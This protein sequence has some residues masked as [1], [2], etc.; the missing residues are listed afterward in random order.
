M[1]GDWIFSFVSRLN[2]PIK[3]AKWI[4]SCFSEA[5][6]WY[7]D[8]SKIIP[9]LKAEVT[10]K[11]N[12]ARDLS[13][14]ILRE[15]SSR[16][17]GWFSFCDSNTH[18]PHFASPLSQFHR[19]FF[20]KL[21]FQSVFS[22]LLALFEHLS[23]I[24]LPRLYYVLS[25]Q[26]VVYFCFNFFSFDPVSQMFAYLICLPKKPFFSLLLLL[27]TVS[28]F[29]MLLISALIFIIS[30]PSNSFGFIFCCPNF[31]LRTV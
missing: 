19:V 30:F 27:L 13:A 8:N 1:K 4:F 3:W 2:S 25:N 7:Y 6:L 31:F 22:G 29:V 14:C 15:R 16:R 17:H 23:F 18:Q 5:I 28:L 12:Q 11:T 10:C 9:L 24:F 20:Q 26:T 21:S